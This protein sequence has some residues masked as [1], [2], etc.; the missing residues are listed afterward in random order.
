MRASEHFSVSYRAIKLLWQL[1]PGC[2]LTLVV[3]SVLE[4]V[5]P[6][7]PV[8]FSAMLIDGLAAGAPV[9]TIMLLA[10]LTVGLTFA[11]NA[12]WRWTLTVHN[13]LYN[14][15]WH[16]QEWIFC[17]KALS[18]AYESLE[19]RDIKL[20]LERI[21]AENQTGY[22]LFYL[23]QTLKLFFRS[24]AQICGGLGVLTGL[25]AA[26]GIPLAFRLTLA[27]GLVL[28]AAFTCFSGKKASKVQMDFMDSCVDINVLIEKY[29]SYTTDYTAG[30]DIRLYG[31]GD[32]LADGDAAVGLQFFKRMQRSMLHNGAWLAP[33]QALQQLLTGGLY[34]LLLWAALIGAVSV[35][36]IARY[37]AC[38]LPL[39]RGV[40][41]LPLT[42]QLLLT[43]NIY[44]K[45]F[46]SYLD[47]PNNMYQGSLTVEKRDDNDYDVEFRDVSFQYPGTDSWALRHVD[48][49]FNVG[50][51]LALVGENGSGKTTF[52]KLLCRLYDP[53]EGSILLGGVDIRKMDYDEYRRLFAVVF[54]DFQLL[55]LTL[56]QNVATQKD[57]DKE[58]VRECLQKAG[59]GDRLDAMPAGC[60]TY[61]YKHYAEDG[62]EISGG[63]AQKIALARALYKD[64]PFIILDEPT[65]ALDPQ[66][67]YRVYSDFNAIAGDK[68]AVYISH[69]L[70]SCRFCD[71]VAVFDGGRLVQR[72]THAA[73]LADTG[74]KYHALWTA[75]A[76][77]YT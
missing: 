29:D 19:N 23:H 76:Q 58:K 8:I 71:A 48:L 56:G 43:N 7:V 67:E 18:M 33:M 62:V 28:T 26:P 65:S 12:L 42:I 49:K 68:T 27:A 73:L 38:L 46:F 32:M 13:N 37:A 41:N 66:A 45:R 59:F 25:F 34:L 1:S 61:L 77:Y 74:G 64:A 69:R 60:D 2:T 6:Y 11:A 40:S 14:S 63:E 5:D 36:S 55:S 47:I 30:K 35:G 15:G 17:E 16:K 22:N 4:G 3:S 54:Q 52:I 50:E 75:Q 20:L 44:L 10:A 70:A 57:Y 31:M 21:R 9:S 24:A 72:G 39:M 51:K 53:T